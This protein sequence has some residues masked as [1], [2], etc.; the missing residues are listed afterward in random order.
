MKNVPSFCIL[1]S[2]LC[3]MGKDGVSC[4]LPYKGIVY[5]GT[6]PITADLNQ[7]CVVHV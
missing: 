5:I 2:K 3:D 7:M 6:W 4:S 1:L